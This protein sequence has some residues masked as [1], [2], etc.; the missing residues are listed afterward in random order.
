MFVVIHQPLYCPVIWLSV[1][2]PYFGIKLSWRQIK[3]RCRFR[4][5]GKDITHYFDIHHTQADTFDKINPQELA[6]CVAALAVMSYVVADM[7]DK[8]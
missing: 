6:L 4:A 2:R 1:S 3:S 7:P 8:L 5:G